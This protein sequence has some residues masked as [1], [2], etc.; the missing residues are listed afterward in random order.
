M[1]AD[2]S[3]GAGMT[4]QELSEARK[5]RVKWAYTTRNVDHNQAV[6]LL[7]GDVKPEAGDLVL[8]RVTSLGQ[9][10]RLE[11]VT[12][13][14]ADLFEGDEIIVAFG[15]RYAPDQFE[16]VVPD[17]L[18]PCHLVAA[19]GVAAR[20]L[21][22]HDRMKVSTKITPLA[23]VADRHGNPLN[24]RSFSLSQ[25]GA[26]ETRPLVLVVAGT[27]MNAGK[28]TAC[29]MLVKGL[30]RR[31][32]QVAAAKMTGTGAGADFRALVDAGADPVYD[33]VDAGYVSTYRVNNHD[34]LDI[35]KVLG[36]HMAATRPDVI[37]VEVA[38]GLLQRET[39]RLFVTREFVDWV[40]G[41]IFAAND[42]LGAQAGVAWL[43][44]RQVPVIGVSGVLTSSPLAHREAEA[45]CGLPVSLT[46]SLARS[47]VAEMIHS[48]LESRR[49][50]RERR[51]EA[52]AS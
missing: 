26:L 10:K 21:N 1:T 19:G 23:L 13:R 2:V 39:S 18:E 44:A 51:L 24:L 33:F 34:L 11:L 5:K 47:T 36:G 41:V 48:C 9:H 46:R 29:A 14:R 38:D 25:P 6:T 8:A 32:F 7:S 17:R 12:S 4:T 16:G 20:M 35:V 45:A 22:R 42:A 40:D 31:G 49:T 28:T 15:N 52:N 43:E 3:W 37:V 50:Q 27:A 30:V